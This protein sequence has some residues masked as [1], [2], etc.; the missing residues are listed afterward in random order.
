MVFIS[1]G[2]AAQQEKR[3]MPTPEERAQKMTDR[4]A[5][6]L[7]LTESQKKEIYTIN[8]ESAKKRQAEMEAHKAERE[9][10]Q[11]EMKAQEE[12]IQQVLTEDQRK[13][14]EEIKLEAKDRRRPGGEIHSRESMR[15]GPRGGN[16]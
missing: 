14:W 10:M 2:V 16:Q 5:E 6:K 12:K 13:Q 9:A 7:T 3:T 11:A 1:L 15:K 8:L 4:M